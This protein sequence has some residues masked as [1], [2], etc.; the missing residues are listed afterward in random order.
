M[1]K[2][3]KTVIYP[4]SDLA[5][6]KALYTRLLGAEPAYDDSYYVGFPIGDQQIGLDPNGKQRGMTGATPFWEVED[7]EGEVAGPVEAGATI[8]EDVHDV[9][10]GGRVA[11]LSDADGNMIGLIT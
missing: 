7:I 4:V 10:G 5:G 3:V 6:A 2:S 1:S 8:V 9:G 11:I